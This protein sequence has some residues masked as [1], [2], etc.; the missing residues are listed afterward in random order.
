[1]RALAASP[2][3][4][5]GEL[6]MTPDEDF[7]LITNTHILDCCNNGVTG[8]QIFYQNYLDI[9]KTPQRDNAERGWIGI[10]N[11]FSRPKKLTVTP[12]ILKLEAGDKLFSV[13][14]N[15][16]LDFTSGALTLEVAP[17]D[18]CFIYYEK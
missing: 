15:R 6:T 4:M 7:A 1:M 17:D 5:G 16:E 14:D 13:W 10:F 3:I 8:K 2:L 9:R 18:V 12:E 11:R